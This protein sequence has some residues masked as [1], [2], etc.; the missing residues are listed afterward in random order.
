MK[1]SKKYLLAALLAA[2][3]TLSSRA[4]GTDAGVMSSLLL[5]ADARTAAMAGA[6]T[7][8]AENPLALHTNAA[9]GLLGE[10][11]S[12][13]ALSAG[14]WNNGFDGA[15]VLYTAGGFHS[16]D[17]RNLILA[18]VHYLNGP[19]IDM[20][21]DEGFPAGSARP[22]DLAAEA[23]YGRLFGKGF[24]L[25]LT[26]RYLRSDAG[27][28]GKPM[29]G[30]AFDLGAAYRHALRGV[31]GGSWT[32]GLRVADAGPRIATDD[33]SR[34]ALPL[35]A[36]L[37]G[38]LQLPFSPNHRLVVSLDA[39]HQFRGGFTHAALG[40][41]YTFLRHGVV[42]GGYRLGQK[43]KGEGSYATV[44][45]G[46]IVGP[47]RCDVAWRFGGPSCNPR[48]KSLLFTVGFLL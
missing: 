11:R 3:C 36:A 23:G 10:H 18:G 9:L 40:A 37:G 4:Q 45:G 16:P 33:G 21:D 34:A 31:A 46:F 30:V 20:T 8:V 28:G 42:R 32:V 2:A 17:G 44:G 27:F 35:R 29:Q 41:E 19:R 13:G 48:N 47:V 5:P 12:G 1:R 43:E 14:P 22:W 24:S 25:A 39:G 38:A 7:A 26:V 15:D 6:A